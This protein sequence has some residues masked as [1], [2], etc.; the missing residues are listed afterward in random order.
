MFRQSRGSSMAWLGAGLVAVATWWCPAA[1]AAPP[2]VY[3]CDDDG[4]PGTLRSL[5]AVAAS[6]DTIDLRPLF[7]TIELTGPI[8][9]P[10]D[11]LTLVGFD[12]FKL[13]IDGNQAGRVFD[14]TG[15]GML[16]LQ[17]MSVTG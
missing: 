15:T 8:T 5:I 9:I 14:H 17:G 11:Q 10:Q 3:S 13:T 16:H 2:Q 7:C 6:G 4:G 1:L 12:R